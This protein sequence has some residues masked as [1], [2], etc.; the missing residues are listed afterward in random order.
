MNFK[1]IKKVGKHDLMIDQDTLNLVLIKEYS[2]EAKDILDKLKHNNWLTHIPHII[3]Y[4]VTQ[5]NVIISHEEYIEGKSLREM[6]DSATYITEADLR[7]YLTNILSTL[8]TLHEQNILHRDIKPDNIIINSD[9]AYLIDFDIS[10]QFNNEKDNDTNLL[11]TKGYASPEQFGFA[12]TTNKSDI[13]S[14]GITLK[15]MLE[16]TI[17]EPNK[18]DVYTKLAEDMTNINSEL[19]PDSAAVYN[20]LLAINNA[21]NHSKKQDK[22]TTHTKTKAK[23]KE[24]F[25]IKLPFIKNE[26]FIPFVLTSH[27]IIANLC[28]NAFLIYMSFAFMS[29]PDMIYYK[30]NI[31]VY[32]IS[33]LAALSL[34][35]AFVNYVTI[36]KLAK[37]KSK[38]KTG[39]AWWTWF[40]YR[41]GDYLIFS[42]PFILLY[43]QLSKLFI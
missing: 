9:G 11:G 2:L 32:L 22:S 25:N 20:S 5:N 14:L 13:Y 43:N 34:T 29:D 30:F 21:E 23:E 12:Q 24:R 40:W 17:L 39:K 19:R 16:I 6:L 10:R 42:A 38:L 28:A 7:L 41:V 33:I 4:E 1:F 8:N 31:F 18:F 3:G 37:R 35:N 26:Y 15:E 36:P 27:G